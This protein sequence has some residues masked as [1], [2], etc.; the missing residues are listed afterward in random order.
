MRLGRRSAAL[1]ALGWG[2]R[3]GAQPKP[4]APD[5]MRILPLVG[6]QRD[7]A[8]WQAEAGAAPHVE[9]LAGELLWVYA[10][11][12]ERGLRTLSRRELDALPPVPGGLR[13]RAI[14]NLVDRIAGHERLIGSKGLTLI[15]V[16]GVF[17]ASML[18]WDYF[19]QQPNLPWVGDPVVVLPARD[20]LLVSGSDDAAALA[21]MRQ[22]AAEMHA[23]AERPLS[24]QPLRRHDGRWQPF[25]T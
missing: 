25:L 9:P 7:L 3:A 24:L 1:L 10:A 17:E 6:T 12:G 16:G 2:L 18:L 11:Q 23:Q 22:I 4:V 20:L 21:R 13:Q 15:A 19:W 8:R 5:V 14:G